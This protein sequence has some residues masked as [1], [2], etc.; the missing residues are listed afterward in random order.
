MPVKKSAASMHLKDKGRSVPS[1]DVLWTTVVGVLLLIRLV[2]KGVAPSG[3]DDKVKH[4]KTTAFDFSTYTGSNW[5]EQ[6]SELHD[7]LC[8]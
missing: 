5:G 3:I 7:A 8:G 6:P 4:K 2:K 1:R